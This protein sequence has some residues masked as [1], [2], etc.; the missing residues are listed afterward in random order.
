MLCLQWLLLC[1]F[2]SLVA[3]NLPDS[4]WLSYTR[5]YL[6]KLGLQSHHT[7]ITDCFPEE[8]L[9]VNSA[10]QH[11]STHSKTKVTRRGRKKGGVRARLKRET[12]K[13]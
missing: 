13:Q 6:I 4:P 9:R 7:V 11:N 3:S 2:A 10:N 5:D 12:C 1:E 8:I